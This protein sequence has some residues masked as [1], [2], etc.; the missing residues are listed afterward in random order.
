MVGE[1]L[2]APL[3]LNDRIKDAKIH[4]WHSANLNRLL[5]LGQRTR[6]QIRSHF[7]SRRVASSQNTGP[8]VAMQPKH[9]T[10]LELETDSEVGSVS[11]SSL[12][13]D[14]TRLS[15]DGFVTQ[16]QDRVSSFVLFVALS[17]SKSIYFNLRDLG[18]STAFLPPFLFL[19][20]S[21]TLFDYEQGA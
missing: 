19:P 17:N 3:H 9:A 13:N 1:N 21:Y 18:P 2:L 16:R 15:A 7:P 11:L 8:S 20:T 4:Q 5:V 12:Y 14:R 6:E 10:K